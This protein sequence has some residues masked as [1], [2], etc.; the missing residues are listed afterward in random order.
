MRGHNQR[1]PRKAVLLV[2]DSTPTDRIKAH[3]AR[4]SR[5]FGIRAE[6]ITVQVLAAGEEQPSRHTK[7]ESYTF[8]DPE[9]GQ[10]SSSLKLARDMSC[11]S[12]LSSETRGELPLLYLP[13]SRR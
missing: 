6:S 9:I 7:A 2:S 8:A 3:K 10:L 1:R 5:Q 4:I 12:T 13:R 11:W